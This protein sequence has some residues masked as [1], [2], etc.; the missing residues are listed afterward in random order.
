MTSKVPI[1]V[2]KILVPTSA[3]KN[4]IR[5][6]AVDYGRQRI[7]LALS[8]ELG[9]TAQPL[10]I[11]ERTNRRTDLHKLRDIC[12]QHAVKRIVVGL[13]LHIDGQRSEMAEE[14][15]RFARRIE[16]E[17]GIPVD[18]LDERLTTWEAG[19]TI[20]QTKSASRS[21]ANLDDVAAAVLLRDYLELHREKS[22]SAPAERD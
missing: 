8:D 10:A 2:A 7:G 4:P 22:V 20:Q 18:L 11:L 13:P 12:R 5:I 17:L 16:K 14:A 3:A 9:V 15:E 6:L 19:Q 21:S 1:A